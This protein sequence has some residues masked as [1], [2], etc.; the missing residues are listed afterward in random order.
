MLDGL[1]LYAPPYMMIRVKLAELLL[2]VSPGWIGDQIFSLNRPSCG[3]TSTALIFLIVGGIMTTWL[4]AKT[5][6]PTIDA[7]LLWTQK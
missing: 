7:L 1:S 3:S 2:S 4:G 5:C 6:H